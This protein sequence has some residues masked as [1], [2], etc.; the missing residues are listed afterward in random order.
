MMDFALLFQ[1]IFAKLKD[2]LGDTP[3]LLTQTL[4]GLREELRKERAAKAGLT[5]IGQEDDDDNDSQD[6][7]D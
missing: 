7:E 5:P 4:E 6:S 2:L 3:K 1:E